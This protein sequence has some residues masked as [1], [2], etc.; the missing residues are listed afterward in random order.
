MLK[1]VLLILVKLI[2]LK[3]Q[4]ALSN[5]LLPCWGAFN[6]NCKLCQKEREA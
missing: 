5:L 6:A 4:A 1:L 3:K 2:G